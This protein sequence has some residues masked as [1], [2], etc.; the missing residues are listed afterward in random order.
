VLKRL[1]FASIEHTVN[2]PFPPASGAV[3]T[4]IVSVATALAHGAVPFTV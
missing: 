3:R 1:T 4:V 2:V